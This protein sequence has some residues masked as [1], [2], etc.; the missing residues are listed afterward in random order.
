MFRLAYSSVEEYGV[1]YAVVNSMDNVGSSFTDDNS[2]CFAFEYMTASGSESEDKIQLLYG[3]DKIKS[4]ET[5]LLES[6]TELSGEIEKKINEISKTS[7]SGKDSNVSEQNMTA[8][9]V[10][11]I[12]NKEMFIAVSRNTLS[13]KDIYIGISRD[14][15]SIYADREELLG[16]YR[17]A[18]AGL[19]VIGFVSIY[20]LSRFMTGPIRTLEKV[21]GEIAEGNL[22]RRSH[23]HSEDE[24]GRLSDSLNLMADKISMQMKEISE[25]A[26]KKE[27]EAK[28]KADFTAAFAH[29]LKTPLTSIIGYA[30]ML[31]TIEISEEE[32]REAYYYI[33]NQGKRLES[34]SRKLL[35]LV[36]M[37]NDKLEF[38]PVNTHDIQENLKNTMR[39]IFKKRQIKGKITLEKA[40]IYGDYELLLSLF[41]NLLDN[42]VKAVENEGYIL[43]KGTVEEDGYLIKVVDNGRGIPENEIGRITEAFYMV[44]KSRSRKEGGAGIGLALCSRIIEL[45]G[46]T[47]QIASKPGEGTVICV[48]F[49]GN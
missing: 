31:N 5:E 9:G 27:L 22:S 10:R 25:E 44:D 16:R 29:E 21:T 19:I 43:F 47:L 36:N 48:R 13:D 41:Y 32:K 38:R 40:V 28:Q 33:Y 24:I 6:M 37:E 35:E 20:F 26:A 8:Y 45:H 15:S 1:E 2:G 12:N 17:L 42:A 39:P 3:T 34:L 7:E 18:L 14:I 30:D 4:Q 49:P 11:K 46:A 23:Y